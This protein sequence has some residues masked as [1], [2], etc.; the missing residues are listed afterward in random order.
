MPI[1]P[2]DAANLAKGVREVY[3]EAEAV[4]LAKIAKALASGDDGPDWAER[5]LLGIRAVTA[6]T[7]KVLADLAA[8]VPGAVE[9]ALQFAYQRGIAAS[10]QEL[11]DSGFGAAAFAE[12]MPTQAVAALVAAT[13]ASQAAQAFQIRRAVADAYQQAITAAT[14]QVLTGT[15]T[16]REAS[17]KAL[18]DLTKNGIAS[19]VDQRGRRWEMGAYNEMAVRSSAMNAMLQGTVDRLGEFGADEV[20]ISDAPEECPRCRP[21][22]GRVLSLSGRSAGQLLGDGVPVFASLE[23]AKAQGLFHNSCRHSMSMYIPGFTKRRA[24]TADPVGSELRVKQRAFERRVRELKRADAIAQ[25]FGG[26]EA[27]AARAK[28]RAKQREF[29]AWREANNRKNLSYRTNIT[30]R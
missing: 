21:F 30:S 26:V 23:D 1:R 8:N 6:A 24:A 13:T 25:E 19:F 15:M 10:S 9:R 3:V 29:T 20:M 28:L 27:T 18:T 4:L 2:D 7:D 17:A 11:A 22:E 5:K 14:A 16:R 12:I